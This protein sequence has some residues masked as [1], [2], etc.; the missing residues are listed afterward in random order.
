M[1]AA[2][3]EGPKNIVVFVRD[4]VK[5]EDLW[6]PRDWAKQNLPNQQ[7]LKDNGLSF[8]NAFT[9]SAMCTAA[10]ASFFTGKFP[11][12]HEVGLVLSDIKHPVLDTQPQLSTDL[13]NLAT[14]LKGQGY[15]VSFIGK[16]HLSKTFTRQDG[17]LVYQ[18]LKSYGFDDWQ[19]PDAGQDME[20]EN[21]GGG[22]ANHDRRYTDQAVQWLA[23]RSASGNAKPFCLVVSLIN[24]HDCL[25]YPN[26]YKDFGYDDSWLKGDIKEL[27]PTVSEI[28]KNNFKPAV[29][30]Q[31]KFVQQ[32]GQPMQNDQQRLEY[33]NFY[34]NLLKDVDSK[35]G[36]IISTLANSA[37]PS[38][39]SSLLQNT[40]IIST[41]DH[42][43]MGLSHGGLVQKMEVA[44]DEALKVPLVWS[45]PQ[46]FKGGQ[47]T[48]AMVSHV[49][50][51]QTLAGY[52]GFDPSYVASQDLR[53]VDYS[54][55]IRYAN[56]HADM[57][58]APEPQQSILFTFDDI[59]AGQD[60]ALIVNGSVE[61]G[62]FP[63]ANRIQAVRTKDF[64]Y[65]RYFSG[66]KAYTPSNWEGELYDLRPHGGDYYPDR[67]PLTGELNPFKGAPLELRNFDPKTG[68]QRSALDRLLP[69][70]GRAQRAIYL[71]MSN[72][73]NEQIDSRLDPLPAPAAK[74]PEVFAYQGGSMNGAIYGV[75]QKISRLLP[76]SSGQDLE[77]A[78]TTQSSQTYQVV[79]QD[80]S[81]QYTTLASDIVGTNGPVYQYI[82]GL[83]L[84][85]ELSDI[86]IQWQGGYQSI[87]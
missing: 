11:A 80:D 77:L 50:F 13:P 73:L 42:G 35:M 39:T 32:I 57:T 30:T 64:K 71:R 84:S 59:Y 41:A 36:E 12:Q 5:P 49:D 63:A 16:A 43:E 79:Y 82:S 34:G 40:M 66:D 60:P 26:D 51:L 25:T 22:F 24:P 54:N 2:I 76:S 27:P 10:R 67:D 23:D 31:W 75:G 85:V 8:S 7:W 1:S 45:N 28:L 38:K 68:G 9:N 44:Y 3:S 69:S 83:P 70:S 37:D 74:A 19:G 87:I 20:I 53:G 78:F 14:V 46:Y 29:Q 55:I 48:D 72:L 47:E 81:G 6:L 62:L 61:H 21:A 65:A 18:D 15:D 58:G 4:Q 52:L 33:L 17:E 86:S 56:D